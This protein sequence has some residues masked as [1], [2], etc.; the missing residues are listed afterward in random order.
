MQT[1]QTRGSIPLGRIDDL[2]TR[3][4]ADRIALTTPSSLFGEYTWKVYASRT[5]LETFCKDGSRHHALVKVPTAANM[6]TNR[7]TQRRA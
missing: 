1:M 4:D 3:A 7:N 6:L 2:R 5:A